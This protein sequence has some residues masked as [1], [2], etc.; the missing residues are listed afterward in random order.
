MGR[1]LFDVIDAPSGW[2][3]DMGYGAQHAARAVLRR[4]PR[5]AGRRAP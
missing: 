5:A 1:N 2:N 3:D 4:H